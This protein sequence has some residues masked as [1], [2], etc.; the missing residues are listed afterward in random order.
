[1]VISALFTKGFMEIV[2]PYLACVPMLIHFITLTI[3]LSR[4]YRNQANA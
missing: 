2:E 3:A 4:K 1:V